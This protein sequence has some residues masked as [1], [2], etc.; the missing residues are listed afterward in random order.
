MTSYVNTQKLV[1]DTT[2]PSYFARADRLDVLGYLLADSSCL[3]PHVVREE[4]RVGI[5]EYPEIAQV[6]DVEWLQVVALDTLDRIRKFA[7][8]TSRVGAGERNLGEASVLAVAEEMNAVALI[9][10]RSASLVG[11]N[12]GVNVHGTVWLLAQ[13]Q[14]NGKLT[15]ISASN[16]IDALMAV[17]MRL[18]C[19]GA[20]YPAFAAANGLL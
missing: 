9:D 19:T 14:Q 2:C 12:Y 16:L 7:I 8:W 15:E 3:M 1:L 5:S 20:E 6:L 13:A 17:G 10:D 4:I 18:P 11:R